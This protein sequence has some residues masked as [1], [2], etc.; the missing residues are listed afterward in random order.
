MSDTAAMILVVV[1]IVLVVALVACCCCAPAARSVAPARPTSCA[2]RPPPS[3]RTSSRPSARP[4]AQQAA[5]EQAR[6]QAEIAEARAAEARQGLA[7]DRGPAAR[8][9]SARPTGS[10]RPSTTA[11]T[12]TRRGDVA[13]AAP[14]PAADAGHPR[15]GHRRRTVAPSARGHGPGARRRRA[16]CGCCATWPASPTRCRS[17][18]S[19]APASCRAARRTTWSPRWSA[20]GF[21]VHLADEH[22]YGL[23]VA[24]FE[25]GSGYARQAPLQRIARRPLAELVD[26]TRQSAHLAVLH[27]GDV[28]YVLEERAPGRPPLVT[29]VGVR[30]PAH[31]TASGRAV[32]AHLPA[33]QV[34]A[35][36]PAAGGVRRPGTAPAPSLAERPAGAAHRDPAARVRRRARAR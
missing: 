23:G 20:E 22:R 33:A 36:V 30:L 1:A 31:L 14:S 19:R 21:V 3:R 7:A 35:L 17:T 26:R 10:T 24:A 2:A 9:S 27:G 11:A 32:L 18:R 6:E 13:A 15:D 34:R 4:P 5:A 25:V 28:L 12:T 8:T 29:D 16:R